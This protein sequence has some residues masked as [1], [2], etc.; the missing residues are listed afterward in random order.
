MAGRHRD[1]HPRR[2]LPGHR[3]GHRPGG[4][5]PAHLHHRAALHPAGGQLGESPSAAPADLV[6]GGPSHG[7]PGRRA[8][9]RRSVGRVGPGQHQGVGHCADRHRRFRGGGDQR[10]RPG[11]GQRAR[12][13]ARPRGGLR[14]RAD[15]DADEERGSVALPRGRSFLRL[16]AAVRDRRGRGRRAVPPAERAP[17]GVAGRRPAAAD[18]GRRP[19]QHL[20]RSDRFRRG[21]ANRWLA[22]RPDPGRDRD[23]GRLHRAIPFTGH[24]ARA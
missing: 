15:R 12:S 6:G 2:G 20:L 10:G 24:R 23:W 3:A 4:A 14:L 8:G 16:V 7:Q 21:R 18:P 1:G 17:S 11:P 9:G 22:G 5:G 19:D 13:G